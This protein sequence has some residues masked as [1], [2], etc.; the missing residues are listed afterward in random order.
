MD[1]KARISPSQFSDWLF[2]H[3]FPLHNEPQKF[4][5]SLHCIYEQECLKQ[6]KA[7]YHYM[8]NIIDEEYCI[9]MYKQDIQQF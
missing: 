4:H 1:V 2:T 6:K 8:Q 7:K 9:T 5:I 3:T